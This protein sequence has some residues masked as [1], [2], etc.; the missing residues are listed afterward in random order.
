MAGP[1][2]PTFSALWHRVR[3]LTPS[4]RAQVQVMR[5]RHR[6]QAWHVLRDPTSGQF[7]RLDGAAWSFVGRLDGRRSVEAI[8]NDLL[9]RDPDGAPTQGEVVGLL[10]RLS[11]ANLVRSDAALETEQLLQRQGE[12]TAQRAKSTL[13]NILFFKVPVFNPDGA[14]GWLEPVFRPVIGRLGFAAWCVFMVFVISK[15]ASAGDQLAAS[16]RDAIAPANVGW[17]LA[18][19]VMAK[20]WHEFGHAVVLK[21]FGGRVPACGFMLL[22]MAPSPYVDASSAWALKSKWKRAA[23]GAAGMMFE[24]TLAGAAAL[25]WMTTTPGTLAHQLAFNCMLTAGVSTVLFNANPLM[26]FDGYFILSDVLDMPN[27]MQRSFQLLKHW[28]ARWLYGAERPEAP[29]VADGRERAF[30]AVYGLAAMAYRVVLFVGI[31]VVLLE[32]LFAIGLLLALWTGGVWLV[33]PMVKLGRYV[34]GD[35]AL[36]RKRGR[37]VVVTAA[38]VAVVG[39][40]VGLVPMQDVRSA[41]GVIASE[42]R[43]PMY[44]RV[45]G[46][47]AASGVREGD[48]VEAGAVLMVLEDE[49]LAARV[50][51]ARVQLE[52]AEGLE[53][54]AVDH[55]PEVAAL[56]RQR[57]EAQRQVVAHLERQVELLTVRSPHAGVVVQGDPS[58]MIGAWVSA[59]DA[60]CTVIDPDH[61]HVDASAAQRDGAWLSAMERDAYRVDIVRVAQVDAVI[62]GRAVEV[63]P[64]GRRDL[65]HSALGAP[66]GGQIATDSSDARGLVAVG[67]RF[68]VRIWAEGLEGAP[69]ERVVVRFRLPR[70][71]L[72]SQ[73]SERVARIV[74]D[75]VRL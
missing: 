54:Q 47:V 51:A 24:L 71:A 32:R 68:P 65:A 14:V 11:A 27:L 22:V 49:A 45:A 42:A 63:A 40:V 64:A 53:R 16:L 37:A 5:Q 7:F 20:T 74:Q 56:A 31:T 25:Y 28:S 44:A 50:R 57:V 8:W 70:R 10:G 43:A 69:G 66:G 2:R 48:A 29:A 9:A 73:W 12:R 17:L 23:V 3:Q 62:E 75:K 33:G 19:Y 4:L 34:L 41:P 52:L 38:L 59:G 21:R 36:Q 13:M 55:A 72:L 67:R 1:E 46:R 58:A 15:L 61:L 6:G 30:L 18:V 60:I 35:A 39:C 26:R